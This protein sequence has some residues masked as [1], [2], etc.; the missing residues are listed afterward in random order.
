MVLEIW[1]QKSEA[2]SKVS[3]TLKVEL[4]VIIANYWKLHLLHV[5]LGFEYIF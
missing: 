3:Q 5:W 4:L 1:M 2:H